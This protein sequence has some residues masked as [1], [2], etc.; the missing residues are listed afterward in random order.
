MFKKKCLD[1]N[2]FLQQNQ[3]GFVIKDAGSANQIIH[4]IKNLKINNYKIYALSPARDMWINKNRTQNLVENYQELIDSCDVVLIGTGFPGEEIKILKELN[5]KKK[6]TI[7]LIDHWT[8]YKLRFLYNK[9]YEFPQTIWVT[10]KY[11]LKIAKN[12][13]DDNIPICL[14]PNFYLNDSLKLISKVKQKQGNFLYLSEPLNERWS[15]S[16]SCNKDAINFCLEKINNGKFGIIKKFLLRPHP[17][18]SITD[19]SWL[20]NKEFSFKIIIDNKNELYKDIGNA[21]F[22]AGCETYALVISKEANKKTFFALPTWAPTSRL[23]FKEIKYIR[24]VI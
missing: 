24:D 23:P 18:Q 7:A 1:L 6:Y 17:S 11:A 13:F 2:F 21:E 9:N 8:N 3:I 4:F 19:F 12:E 16:G 22:I 5:R 15:K 10:D 20:L 14:I